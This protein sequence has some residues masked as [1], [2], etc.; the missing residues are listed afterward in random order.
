[1]KFWVSVS[2]VRPWFKNQWAN[3]INANAHQVKQEL[4]TSSWK[5]LNYKI[6]L[7]E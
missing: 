7:I 4:H 5:W 2:H 3:N 1:M 6:L